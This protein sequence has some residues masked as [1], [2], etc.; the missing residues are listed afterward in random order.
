MSVSRRLFTVAFLILMVVSSVACG[1]TVSSRPEEEYLD[2]ADAE[3]IPDPE[4]ESLLDSDRLDDDIRAIIE[5]SPSLELPESPYERID[6]DLEEGLIDRK[7]QVLLTLQA[8]YAPDA[9]PEEYRGTK[10]VDGKVTLRGEIQWLINHYDELDEDERAIALPFVT[11]AK[12][13]RSYFHPAFEE[14]EGGLR[15]FRVSATAYAAEVDWKDRKVS[16]PGAPEDIWLRHREKGLSEAKRAEIA[17][18]ITHIEVALTAAWPKFKALLGVQPSEE[19]EIFLTPRLAPDTNGEA[20]Y[21]PTNGG[22]D[23]YEI[24]LTERLN[25]DALRSVTVHELFHLFQY[26]MGLTWF[27]VSPQLDWLTEAT[28][29]WS[30]DYMQADLYPSY[31]GEHQYLREFFGNLSSDRLSCRATREYASYVL[32]RFLTQQHGF[33][34]ADILH[35]AAA[36]KSSMDIRGMLM[37]EMGMENLRELYGE[38]ALCNWNSDPYQKYGDNPSF[39]PPPKPGIPW[40]KS[41]DIHPVKEVGKWNYSA[42]MAQGGITYQIFIFDSSPDEV[43]FVRFDFEETP[44]RVDD[45]AVVARQALVKI[46]DEWSREDWTELEHREFC[47]KKDEENVTVVVLIS[48]NAH[49][50]WPASYDFTLTA[51]GDCPMK[52]YTSITWELTGEAEGVSVD[53]HYELYSQDRVEYCPLT[54]SLVLIEREVTFESYARSAMPNPFHMEGVTKVG[55]DVVEQ[56]T[57]GEGN[58]SETY[59]VEDEH[60]K[61]E[62]EEDGVVTI[63]LFPTS[64]TSGWITYTESGDL[65]EEVKQR[66][67]PSGMPRGAIEFRDGTR[68]YTT[69]AAETITVDCTIDGMMVSGV[70]TIDTTEPFGTGRYTVEFEY[71]M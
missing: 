25:G 12:D 14:D 39:P 46:G 54:E 64:E 38:F 52:G 44:P 34:M 11:S 21:Y 59:S 7:T 47:R 35:A 71:G 45:M 4:G 55:P 15:E 69:P 60:I 27:D 37:R 51:D 56:T 9:L 18:Q 36:E 53:E 67:R 63:H 3:W 28:A 17:E 58:L 30:E 66:D 5:G 57:I 50:Q 19:M 48:S 33:D 43:G 42:D 23:S 29:V 26:E 32:F 62:F 13:P 31:N 2:L 41:R 40:G 22:I 20:T 6:A 65:R 10:Y 16:I 70:F 8:A 1:G 68:T 24:H 61:L 49:L